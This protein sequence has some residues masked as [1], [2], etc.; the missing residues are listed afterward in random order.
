MPEHGTPIYQNPS[1]PLWIRVG[2]YGLL[3]HGRLLQRGQ[4]VDS[5]GCGAQ[6]CEVYRGIQRARDRGMLRSD[7][8]AKVLY[9][10][11]GVAMSDY[12]AQF[13]GVQ[14]PVVPPTGPDSV[15]W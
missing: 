14:P 11:Y 3:N 2:L 13:L 12:T 1:I 15:R 8:S 4:L 9:S 7:S 6:D 10:T 5:V